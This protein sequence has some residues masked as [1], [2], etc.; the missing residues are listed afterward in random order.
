MPL[1]RL[2]VGSAVAGPGWDAQRARTRDNDP[3]AEAMAPAALDSMKIETASGAPAAAM[4]SSQRV[5][6][7]LLT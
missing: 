5:L 6:A 3:P 2:D 4:G 7:S 1:L